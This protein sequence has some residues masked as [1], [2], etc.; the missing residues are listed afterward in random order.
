MA[1]PFLSCP[2]YNCIGCDQFQKHSK[3]E[4]DSAAKDL[5]LGRINTQL[6][7]S[8]LTMFYKTLQT[9]EFKIHTNNEQSCICR[10]KFCIRQL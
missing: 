8:T 6:L 9:L 4:R 1:H 7:A 3:T 2:K 5:I 10:E